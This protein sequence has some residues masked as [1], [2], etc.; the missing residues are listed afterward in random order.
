MLLNSYTSCRGLPLN[1]WMEEQDFNSF[2]K[3]LFIILPILLKHYK[4]MSWERE[5]TAAVVYITWFVT[6]DVWIA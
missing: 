1:F 3:T 5:R 6:S 2:V 4:T